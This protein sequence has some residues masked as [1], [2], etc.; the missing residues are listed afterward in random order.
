MAW[1]LDVPAAGSFGDNPGGAGVIGIA[2]GLP[3]GSDDRPLG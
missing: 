1:E 3:S 2:A